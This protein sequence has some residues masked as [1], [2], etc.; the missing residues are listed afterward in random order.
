M[1]PRSVSSRS[2]SRVDWHSLYTAVV[3]SHSETVRD[4]EWRS[5]GAHLKD[6]CFCSLTAE[7]AD[8]HKRAHLREI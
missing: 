6:Q 2:D 5:F 1:C 3:R 4:D 8:Q 7:D